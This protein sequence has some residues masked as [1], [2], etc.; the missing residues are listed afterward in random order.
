[1]TGNVS[2]TDT[3]CTLPNSVSATGY[4]HITADSISGSGK[5]LSSGTEIDINTTGNTT[6]GNLTASNYYIRVRADNISAGD[7][8]TTTYG[9]ILLKAQGN[10][11]VDDV[12]AAPGYNIDLKANAGGG[13]SLFTIGS[14]GSNAVSTITAHG[15]GNSPYVASTVVYVTNGT[16]S[17]TGGITVSDPSKI[18]AVGGS[19]SRS[20]HII[21]NAQ[22]G[23]L[24]I[25]S[26]TLSA[27]GTSGAGSI[28]LLASTIAFG[29]DAI[30][31]ASQPGAAGGTSHGIAMAAE[32]VT[33]GGTN[34]LA[35]HADGNGYSQYTTGF[36]QLMTQGAV[37]VTD[38]EDPTNLSIYGT[39]DAYKAGSVSYT[40]SGSA[41]LVV[42]GNGS[43]N[44]VWVYGYPVAF[45]GGTVLLQSTGVENHNIN[46]LYYGTTSGLQ[47]LQFNGGN[48]TVDASGPSSGNGA[49]GTIYVVMDR[50]YRS[51]DGNATFKA[52]GPSS[53]TGTGGAITVYAGDAPA[54][55]LGTASGRYAFSAKGGSSS[56]NGGAIKLFPYAATMTV[57]GAGSSTTV[58]DVS[59]PGTTGNGGEIEIQPYGGLSFDG[60]ASYLK[61]NSGSST[62]DGGKITVKTSNTGLT[63]GSGSTGAV[64]ISASSNGSGKG[65]TI[66]ILS[67]SGLTVNAANLAVNATGDKQG[68]TIKLDAG[69]S[70]FTFGGNLSANGGNTDGDGGSI[71]LIGGG[72]TL[73][74]NANTTLT[75]NGNGA[76]N[77]GTI[78]LTTRW[79]GV[80]VS[81]ANQAFTIEAL[82]NG[83]GDGGTVEIK[84]SPLVTLDGASIDV[85]AGGDGEGGTI[86]IH[87]VTTL[88]LS[89][90]LHADGAGA[91]AGGSITL[92]PTNVMDMDDVDA[93]TA[94]GGDTG[95]GGHVELNAENFDINTIVNVYPEG[96][97][98]AAL[99]AKKSLKV[100]ALTE[101][102]FGGVIKNGGV[103][104]R[105]WFISPLNWPLYWDC[106]TNWDSPPASNLKPIE[107]A[108]ASALSDVRVTLLDGSYTTNIYLFDN[109]VAYNNFYNLHDSSGPN[110]ARSPA[111]GSITSKASGS[112]QI[113]VAIWRN[114]SIADPDPE[115]SIAFTDAMLEEVTV[116]E[117]GH[118]VDVV[119]GLPSHGGTYGAYVAR[120]KYDLN[121]VKNTSNVWIDR[122][123]CA[124]T[125]LGGGTTSGTAPFAGVTDLV[126]GQPICVTDAMTGQDILNPLEFI[127]W[128][129]AN[130]LEIL[131][132]LEQGLYQASP[133]W[134]ELH[135]QSLAFKTV[136][137]HGARPVS[138]KVMA[139]GYF[140]CLKAWSDAELAGNANPSPHPSTASGSCGP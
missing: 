113:T 91:G 30:V 31:T 111:E 20:G 23:T 73:P 70:G 65:G 80:V 56:G 96:G 76:G 8:K 117:L 86:N 5:N 45:S 11:G 77:G 101:D 35:L 108:S 37:A 116:H 87:D 115:S 133:N 40:G 137:N 64:D 48:V 17:S 106:T 122:L 52:N 26:G 1:M 136:G 15:S 82:S 89:G 107:Q 131:E 6:V 98:V 18:T 57:Y 51:N 39:T 128:T 29:N 135:A 47:A 24:T 32:T 58:L 60:T 85:S 59:V 139:N 63:I 138:D 14:T 109:N 53:G 75:A 95:E 130:N 2:I 43:H 33:F 123:P 140:T 66:D 125:P 7:V 84:E 118:A 129:P 13:N 88:E 104:C 81:S 110:K 50:M 55:N 25:G 132:A 34:G 38:S 83:T 19:G 120:D 74:S 3:S 44:G 112:S 4:I 69:W 9:N 114:G 71:T 105:A 127:G 72:I 97:E 126:T 10:L 121:K 27:D 103:T 16:S 78:S 92:T 100:S 28:G 41:P 134:H 93:I 49:G 21:L 46:L 79:Q 124:P 119:N 12:E 42:T 62:G 90:E 99:M 22:D 102:P 94:R 54:F 68:G 67:Y 61:A 36:V